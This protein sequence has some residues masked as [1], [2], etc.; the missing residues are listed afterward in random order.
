MLGNTHARLT[1][2]GQTAAQRRLS[3]VE[4]WNRLH[5]FTFGTLDPAVEGKLMCAL[6]TSAAADQYLSDPLLEKLLERWRQHP[7]LDGEAIARFAD[8]WPAG[9]NHPQPWVYLERRKPRNAEPDGNSDL[10]KEGLLEHGLCLRLRLPYQQARITD[11]R[12]NGHV[13]PPSESHGFVQWVARGSTYIQISIPAERLRQD[14]LFVVTCEYDPGET[15]PRWD[16]RE[17][18]GETVTP[19]SHPAQ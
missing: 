7:R 11:L 15:R 17:I 10:P 13:L 6:G 9:Q 5:E 18:L 4:L 16:Y 2:Y 8:G 14:D 19:D 3:R 12:C 1:A